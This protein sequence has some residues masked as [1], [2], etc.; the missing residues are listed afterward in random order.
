[1]SI[2]NTGDKLANKCSLLIYL[3]HSW[4]IVGNISLFNSFAFDVEIASHDDDG[5]KYQEMQ[6]DFNKPISK[7]SVIALP[8]I[9][10]FDSST[11]GNN[12]IKY[13]IMDD[14]GGYKSKEVIIKIL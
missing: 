8:P 12:K 10:E 3:P 9:L 13:V 1:M 4:G 14:C 11:K 7:G 6:I 2:S 5:G